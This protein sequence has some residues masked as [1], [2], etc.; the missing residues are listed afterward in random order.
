LPLLLGAESTN[1]L[2]GVLTRPATDRKI[3]DT[4][5]VAV[6]DVE[7]GE[8]GAGS[9]VGADADAG[10]DAGAA[11]VVVL[12]LSS[13]LSSLLAL[14]LF[15]LPATAAVPLLST[16]AASASAIASAASAVVAGMANKRRED[17]QGEC[18]LVLVS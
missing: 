13:K 5:L 16:G 18:D 6:E 11:L 9:A 8:R 14:F 10:A 1:R 3:G 17:L 15:L 4:G 2:K 7:S 12:L